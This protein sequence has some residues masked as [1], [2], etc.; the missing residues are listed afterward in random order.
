[1]TT[2]LFFSLTGALKTILEFLL[3]PSFSDIR[4]GSGG[5]PADQRDAAQ[6]H[7]PDIFGIPPPLVALPLLTPLSHSSGV[8]AGSVPGVM[9]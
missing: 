6:S 2:T 8:R 3:Y 1:M 9:G 4:M 5:E 7:I